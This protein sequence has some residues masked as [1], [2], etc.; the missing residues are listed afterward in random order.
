MAYDEDLADRVRAVL[1]RQI[2]DTPSWIRADEA[3]AG[4]L[5]HCPGSMS[6]S[7]VHARYIAGLREVNRQRRQRASGSSRLTRRLCTPLLRSAVG[8]TPSWMPGAGLS[9]MRATGG[10]YR[11]YP[12]PPRALR[13]RSGT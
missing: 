12:P 13:R 3:A 6:A 9:R 5:R 10:N 8:V 11:A 1:P 4:S 2:L 7:Q